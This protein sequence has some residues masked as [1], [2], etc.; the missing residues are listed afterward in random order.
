M[1]PAHT[2]P[3][4]TL[5]TDFGLSDHYVGTM[6]G[7]ILSR[8]PGAQIIDIAHDL[9]A[10]SI[11]SGAYTIDQSA[12]YFPNGTVH[13]VVIDPGVGTERRAMVVEAGGQHFV[14]PDNGVFSFILEGHPNARCYRIDNKDL[15]LPS[16]SKTFHGRDIFAPAGAAL[17]AGSV[18]V[19]AVG[20]LITDPI[21]LQNL[22]PREDKPGLWS[23]KVLHVDHFGNMITGFRSERFLTHVTATFLLKVANREISTFGNTFGEM[24]TDE[25]FIYPGSSGYLEIGAKQ[26]SA[27]EK[28]GIAPGEPVI[29]RL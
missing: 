15:M 3:T 12:P 20:A 26:T 9:P 28:V 5:T 19:E 17:A 29:L 18:S 4:I 13:V 16:P 24:E 7:V 11:W 2:P 1:P 10:F 25:L 21:R 27:A 23:G 6:K 22:E 8:C 14:G